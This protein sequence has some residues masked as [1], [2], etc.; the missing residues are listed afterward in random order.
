[1]HRTAGFRSRQVSDVTGLAPTMCILGSNHM[2]SLV[3]PSLVGLA[4]AAS[5]VAAAML[6]HIEGDIVS[7]S[8]YHVLLVLC[9]LGT[10]LSAGGAIWALI[11]RSRSARR[12][13]STLVV[14]SCLAVVVLSLWIRASALPHH[15]GVPMTLPSR[16]EGANKS[17]AG[18]NEITALFHAG[19]ACPDLPERYRR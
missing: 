7:P 9:W 3:Y 1:M 15:I 8:D 6:S 4:G 19:P 5:S 17:A 14:S 10:A 2:T 11:V 12:E 18:Q 13:M 16:H